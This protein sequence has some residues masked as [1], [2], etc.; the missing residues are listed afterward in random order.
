MAQPL[1]GWRP[2]VYLEY[3]VPLGI[4]LPARGE[5]R[6]EARVRDAATGR[7]LADVLVRV[8]DRVAVTDRRGR[9]AFVGLP[10]G[11]HLLRVEMPAG[12]EMVT[13]RP[14]PVPVTVAGGGLQTHLHPR[15]AARLIGT[16][17]RRGVDS[18]AA[19]MAGVTVE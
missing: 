11:T 2:Q 1:G 18:V 16:V 4:P 3:G 8:G 6:V 15:R 10:E 19:P 12:P 17:E 14:L 9:A 5:A 13:D 7:G